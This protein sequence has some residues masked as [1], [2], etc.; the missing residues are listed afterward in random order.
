M[1]EAMPIQTLMTN[2]CI[3][4]SETGMQLEKEQAMR[5]IHHA[6]EEARGQAFASRV[7]KSL[8][9][10]TG[11]AFDAQATPRMVL[12][13]PATMRLMSDAL[14]QRSKQERSNVKLVRQLLRQSSK[15]RA[16]KCAHGSSIHSMSHINGESGIGHIANEAAKRCRR[17]A[18]EAN[19]QVAEEIGMIGNTWTEHADGAA[20]MCVNP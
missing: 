5:E 6:T 14:A 3:E 13:L 10:R 18:S 19:M 11:M 2:A 7:D 12:C 16:G 17:A 9:R 15:I 8:E 1:L 4:F 20:Y